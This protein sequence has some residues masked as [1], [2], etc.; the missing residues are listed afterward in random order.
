M[1]WRQLLR[2]AARAPSEAAY[3]LSRLAA[4]GAIFGERGLASLF[5]CRL[6]S[7]LHVALEAS[8]SPSAPPRVERER[9]RTAA[10]GRG[11]PLPCSTRDQ[12]NHH[13]VLRRIHHQRGTLQNYL[14]RRAFSY[15]TSPTPLPARAAAGG[16][17]T[18]VGCRQQGITRYSGTDPP[19]TP[20]PTQPPRH[21]SPSP[22]SRLAPAP[23]SS[24]RVWILRGCDRVWLL[25][26]CWSGTLMATEP[27]G[28]RE[29]R[30][31]F[32]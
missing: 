31:V 16:G 6:D 15:L 22:R 27:Q 14:P 12:V 24:G 13:G 21:H 8:S 5:G 28:C 32:T 7:G 9:E 29:H 3:Q 30:V 2:P 19:P 26:A 4:R 17:A 1:P 20:P 11:Q 18:S 10:E 23:P 25:L